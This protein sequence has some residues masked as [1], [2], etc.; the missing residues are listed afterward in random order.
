MGILPTTSVGVSDKK[1]LF[2]QISDLLRSYRF[3]EADL[4]IEKHWT[5]FDISKYEVAKAVYL[6]RY[7]ND[8]FDLK[9]S[10]DKQQLEAIASIHK[11]TLVTARAWSGKT[12]VI[13]WKTAYL[14]DNEKLS[15]S[16][17]LLL[18]FNKKAANEMNERIQKLSKKSFD[19]AMTFHSLAYKILWDENKGKKILMNSEKYTDT[20]TGVEKEYKTNKQLKFIQNCFYSIYGWNIQKTMEKYLISELNYFKHSS[21]LDDNDLYYNY[22]KKKE[23][24]AFSWDLIRSRGEKYIID[25]LFEHGFTI[26]YEPYLKIDKHWSKP[27]VKCNIYKNWIKL[28]SKD[29]IIEHWWFDDKDHFKKLPIWQTISWKEYFVIRERKIKYWKQEEQKWNCYFLQTHAKDVF[30]NRTSFL[31]SFEKEIRNILTKESVEFKALERSVLTEKLRKNEKTIFPLT[32][33][34]EHFINK[35]QQKH[36]SPE[37]IEKLIINIED[38]QERAFITIAN[39]TYKKYESEKKRL[40]RIDFNEILKTSAKRLDSS[41]CD[42]DIKLWNGKINLKYIKYL[43]IDEYQDFS[44]LFY[45]LLETI[46]KY[47][48]KCKLFFVWDSWQ[49]INAF[50]GSEI[51]YFFDFQKLFS[52]TTEKKISTNYRSFQSIVEMWNTLMESEWTWK[53]KWLSPT[54]DGWQETTLI[55]ASKIPLCENKTINSIFGERDDKRSL[56]QAKYVFENIINIVNKNKWKKV[57]FISRTNRVFW[58]DLFDLRMKLYQYYFTVWLKNTKINIVNNT[59]NLDNKIHR[60]DEEKYK[61]LN[62]LFEN[63]LEFITAHKSKGKEADIVVLLDID[64]K[65]YPSSEK[66]LK[67]DIKYDRIFGITEESLLNDERRLF[68]VAITRAKE[69][70]YVISEE[71]KK[72]KLF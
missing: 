15:A 3:K 16:E 64:E 56:E 62:K 54:H 70:L 63:N 7:F 53:A 71:K 57:M 60:D 36:L 49:S 44:T 2:T 25:F 35:A 10:Y 47:N 14:L 8:K 39:E 13:A 42:I 68:Y 61:S 17:I 48:P 23:Y 69:K 67:W 5:L 65:K 12:Q 21:Y 22:R 52:S 51:W 32:K 43:I 72:T 4:M 66:S 28:L 6:G 18:S 46:L 9:F 37:N 30:K 20:K 40:N 11:N 19:N 41:E 1:V 24:L 33:K 29:I 50:A 34:L 27:D 58:H 38:E 55:D 59:S 31:E 45:M 26:E